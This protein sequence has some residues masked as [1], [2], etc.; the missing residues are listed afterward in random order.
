VVAKIRGLRDFFVTLFFVALGMQLELGAPQVLVTALLLS[1]VVVIS[2]FVTVAPMLYFAGYGPRV[3][4][5]S[6]IALSQAGEFS[7]V[8]VSIGLTLGHIDREVTSIVALTLVIT[9]TLS[10]YMVMANHRLARLAAAVLGRF[11]I[12]DPASRVDVQHQLETIPEVVVLGFHRVASSLVHATQYGADGQSLLVVDFSPEVYRKL[13]ALEVPVLYGDISHLDTLAHAGVE[14]A[15]II[16]STVSDDFL[17]GLDN[18]TLLRTV[19]RLNPRAHVIV[20][21]ETI[22]QARRMYDAGADY[23]I[24]PRIETARAVLDVLKAIEGGGLDD[25]RA[26]AVAD[27]TDRDEVLA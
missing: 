12:H 4:I 27:L 3:G 18:A 24:L 26:A 15:R 23:V 10:T 25:L 19:K 11:G 22:E 9:A 6:S 20:C 17:R 21:A 5:L 14:E 7:L 8:I 2:R 1:A 13:R 16:L